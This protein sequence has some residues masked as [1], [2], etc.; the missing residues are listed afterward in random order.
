MADKATLKDSDLT[1]SLLGTWI[2]KKKS[3]TAEINGEVTL[4]SNGE[5]SAVAKI[6]INGAEQTL[7]YGGT[8]SVRDGFLIEKITK[9]SI[10]E[11]NGRT[12]KDQVVEVNDR[13]LTYRT[14]HG[15]IET[16]KRKP[17]EPQR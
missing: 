10:P 14:Q 11:R 12:T 2:V 5:F 8:W 9:H 1:K 4:Y 13:T 6:A 15:E 7:S 3:P 17:S 16:R